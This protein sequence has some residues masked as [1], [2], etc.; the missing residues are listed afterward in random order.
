MITLRLFGSGDLRGPDDREI[1]AVLVQPKRLALLAFL[2]A[3]RPRGLHSR[4]T[5]LALLWPHLDQ[6]HA[7]AALRTAIHML[8]RSIGDELLVSRG[9]GALGVNEEVLWCDAVAFEC[10]FQ[11]A[12]YERA[13]ELYRDELLT[14]FHLSGNGEFDRWLELERAR[15]AGRAALAAWSVTD[16]EERRGDA[17]AALHWARRLLAL[18]PDDERAVRRVVTLLNQLGDRVGALRECENFRRRIAADYD[19]EPTEET[20]ALIS[21]LRSRRADT[22]MTLR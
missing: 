5:L 4:D 10:A 6:I 22:Q 3:A 21:T 12:D 1:R 18:C 15:L 17:P 16:R 14:G 20:E 7:R 19:L 8:R 11:A 2:A 9:E 13:L